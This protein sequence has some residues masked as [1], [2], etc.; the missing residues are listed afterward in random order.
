[1]PR[2]VHHI[3][4][5]LD[6]EIKEV[7][8]ARFDLVDDLGRQD[9]L[10]ETKLDVSLREGACLPSTTSASRESPNSV[11]PAETGGYGRRQA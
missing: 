3:E 11:S 6:A 8:C 1:M 10:F 2:R 4:L 5:F 7:V 9:P